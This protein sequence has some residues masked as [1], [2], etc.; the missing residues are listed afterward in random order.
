[1]GRLTPFLDDIIVAAILLLAFLLL[2]PGLFWWAFVGIALYSGLKLWLFR[3]HL[4]RPAIGVEA[5]VGRIATAREDLQPRGHV[6][7]D[8]EIW[9]AEAMEPVRA[10][11]KV[12]VRAV[13]GLT[14]RVEPAGSAGQGPRE[15]PRRRAL[16][17]LPRWLGRG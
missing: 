4:R 10:G 7:L 5:M 1:M 16:P 13:E 15:P 14:L 9:Q 11:E 12:L 6:D 3:A 17:G 2:A 8:G